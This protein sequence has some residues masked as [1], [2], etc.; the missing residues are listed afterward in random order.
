MGARAVDGTDTRTLQGSVGETAG[1]GASGGDL[2]EG[3]SAKQIANYFL[4]KYGKHGI[5]PLK[6]QKLVYLAHGWHLAYHGEPLVKDENAEAWRY[7][8]VFS[9]LYHHFKDRGR[10]PIGRLA[11]NTEVEFTGTRDLK[12]KTTR[13]RIDRGD[14]QTSALLDRIWEVY[15]NHSGAYLSELCHQPGSP[16]DRTER[17]VRNAHIDNE[18]IKEYYIKIREKNKNRD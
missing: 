12:F 13:P 1:K 10:K 2:T 7:G 3:Y 6:L 5:T 9:S 8:P 18:L 15:G 4:S 17:K 11:E 16:W 14:K